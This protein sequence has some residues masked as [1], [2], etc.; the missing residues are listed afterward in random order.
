MIER[1]AAVDL[2]EGGTGE[3][4]W[5]KRRGVADEASRK[6]M[7]HWSWFLAVYGRKPEGAQV[8]N[9]VGGDGN[10]GPE[11]VAK[12]SEWLAAKYGI[13]I[14]AKRLPKASN[15]GTAVDSSE[16][17]MVPETKTRGRPSNASSA[18]DTSYEASSSRFRAFASLNRETSDHEAE[19]TPSSNSSDADDEL[20]MRVDAGGD[21]VPTRQ[22]LVGLVRSLADYADLL[23]WRIKHASKDT[24]GTPTEVS[25]TGQG[26]ERGGRTGNPNA[27]VLW[28]QV[29]QAVT[30]SSPPRARH[31]TSIPFPVSVRPCY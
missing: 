18:A 23:D 29:E 22:D 28:R 14:E 19:Y 25:K 4:R 26:E 6:R 17:A 15:E 3:V 31:S 7:R 30:L 24:K 9:S 20:Y 21:P 5:G 16:P 12:L 2:L 8:A 27:V 10:A 1:E 13:D 11:E